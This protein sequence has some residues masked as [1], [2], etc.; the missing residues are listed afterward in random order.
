MKIEE[1]GLRFANGQEACY[2]RMAGSSSSVLVVPITGDNNLLL[3][4]EYAVGFERYEFGFVK[5]RIENTE[6]PKFAASREMR[7]E[8]GFDAV[9][10]RQLA[11]V[12]LTPGYSNH[13]TFMFLALGLFSSPLDGDEP[14]ELETVPWSLKDLD[15]LRAREDFTDARCLLATYLVDQELA[16]NDG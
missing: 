9:E 2:E 4:Q 5:G 7:E 6:S 13:K 14:E 10:Y 1:V 12:S 3:V 11:T 15:Q 16:K 8:I